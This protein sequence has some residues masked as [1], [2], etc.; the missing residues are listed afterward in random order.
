MVT[1]MKNPGLR[2][3]PGAGN[4]AEKHPFSKSAEIVVISNKH[5]SSVEALVSKAMQLTARQQ[6]RVQ[7]IRRRLANHSYL[8][9]SRAIAQAMLSDRNYIGDLTPTCH[10]SI[11]PSS[12]GRR[13]DLSGRLRNQDADIDTQMSNRLAG[14][15]AASHYPK[16][17][18][19]MFR[20]QR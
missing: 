10:D 19:R 1:P 3:A 6:R 16:P 5:T 12:P 18:T 20:W 2:N 14:G 8:L 13:P 15:L 9:E 17:N 11:P 7:G 4:L